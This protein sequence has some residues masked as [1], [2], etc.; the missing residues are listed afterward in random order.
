MIQRLTVLFALALFAP[1]LEAAP[2]R[3]GAVPSWVERLPLPP[4]ETGEHHRRWLIADQQLRLGKGRDETYVRWAQEITDEKALQSVSQVTVSFDPSYEM[5]TLHSVAVLRAGNRI[6][7]LRLDAIKVVQ[8]EPNLEAQMYDGR[9]SLVLFVEDLRIGDV[10][11]VEY[12]ITGA[13]PTLGGHVEQ[14]L[15]LGT[16]L[17][18]ARAHTRIIVPPGTKL[19]L[20]VHGPDSAMHYPSRGRTA[21]GDEYVFDRV[22]VPAYTIEPS[23]PSW[24]HAVPSLELSDFDSWGMV[25]AWTSTL[26]HVPSTPSR[27]LVA[28]ARRLRQRAPSNAAFAL[29]VTRFVQDEIRYVALSTGLSRRR[30]TDPDV[31]LARRFGDC[32]DKTILLATLLRLGG[33]DADP[34]LVSTSWR[35]HLADSL[36][37][38]T[39]FNHAIVHVRPGPISEHD[40]WIDPTASLQGGDLSRVRYS[41]L[42]R[43]LV[44]TP[45]TQVLSTLPP[46]LPRQPLAA[47]TDEYELP[48]TGSKAPARL[49]IVR[50][51]RGGFADGMRHNFRGATRDR[52]AKMYLQMYARRFPSIAAAEPID[53]RDDREHDLLTVEA[54]F[55]IAEPW[56]WEETRRRWE[57]TVETT[58]LGEYLEKPEVVGRIAPLATEHPISVLYTIAVKTPTAWA[59]NTARKTVSGPAFDLVLTTH[60]SDHSLRY[61]YSFASTAELV[62]LPQLARHAAAVDDAKLLLSHLVSSKPIAEG[63]NP[64][65]WL[66]VVLTAMASAV[67]G[68]YVYRRRSGAAVEEPGP[69]QP[70]T[71]WLA[72]VALRVFATPAWLLYQLYRTRWFFQRAGWLRLVDPTAATY[73][74]ASAATILSELV[75]ETFFGCYGVLLIAALLQRRAMFR[76]HFIAL[77]IAALVYSAL[78]TGVVGWIHSSMDLSA[79]EKRLFWQALFTVLFVRYVHV[80]PRVKETFTRP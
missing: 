69:R 74:P 6:D 11:D 21:L 68:R 16:P 27:T 35:D 77:S 45:T 33:I 47:I 14:T 46:E 57:T 52:I 65:A 79:H 44:L 4:L 41:P 3:A 1:R 60:S 29:A 75:V 15:V 58:M 48:D 25:A 49:R 7:R 76:V 13:D 67:A 23:L 59:D 22:D 73:R 54:H 24:F 26:L 64:W 2:F 37:R 31:V 70:L 42:G 50:Q 5:V 10:L 66:A 36:P 51:F 20:R 55:T 39:A 9:R 80:S 61:D 71:G 28:E 53:I 38:A 19:Q 8:R 40:L 30:A 12:T 62:E 72:V 34:A 56:R 18:M 32:K 63:A 17:P 78:D 43:A